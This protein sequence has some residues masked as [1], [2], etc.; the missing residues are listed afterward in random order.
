MI[1]KYSYYND[2]GLVYEG[3]FIETDDIQV[4]DW[5]LTHHK[6]K[7]CNVPILQQVARKIKAYTF[8]SNGVETPVYDLITHSGSAYKSNLKHVSIYDSLDRTIDFT[9]HFNGENIRI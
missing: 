2:R 3:R 1:A 6:C 4:G 9:K 5:F 8:I 7:F